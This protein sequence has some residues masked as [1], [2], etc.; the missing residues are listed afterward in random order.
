MGKSYS[1]TKLLD[2]LYYKPT[3]RS[4]ACP[5]LC[6]CLC[7]A[8]SPVNWMWMNK[9]LHCWTL[10]Q[11]GGVFLSHSLPLLVPFH[12]GGRRGGGGGDYPF[13]R[14]G[15]WLT[16]LLMCSLLSCCCVRVSV[17]PFLSHT[18][19]SHY[20]CC[21]CLC[22]H[23]FSLNDSRKPGAKLTNSPLTSLSRPSC[24]SCKRTWW[25]ACASLWARS[26]GA[27]ETLACRL[28]RCLASCMC[29]KGDR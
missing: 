20:K 15:H 10:R 26:Q 24:K 14:L 19:W 3:V 16:K 7:P 22:S 28:S 27:D 1:T 17:M 12:R 21:V 2:W 11:T 9:R 18:L 23:N 8:C 29:N 13:H 25:C 6:L 4:S 5:S